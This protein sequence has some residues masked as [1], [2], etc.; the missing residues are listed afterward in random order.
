MDKSQW[1]LFQNAQG[2]QRSV[3]ESGKE[4]RINAL[5]FRF[6]SAMSSVFGGLLRHDKNVHASDVI[7]DVACDRI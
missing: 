1:F 2:A 7:E 3:C 5:R 4:K 6:F